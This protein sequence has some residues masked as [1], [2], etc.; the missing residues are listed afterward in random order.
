ANHAD[1]T[2]AAPPLND[3]AMH[4][5]QSTGYKFI[6]L[7]G[8]VDSNDNG[9]IDSG[10]AT[11]HYVIDTDAFLDEDEVHVHHDLA[12]G[13]QFIIQGWADMSVVLSGVDV[14]AHQTTMTA[15]DLPLAT[16]I[17]DSLV[18]SLGPD[19]DE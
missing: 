15:D 14:M 13:E 11:F 6:V 5:D 10:D 3:L 12:V 4:V 1:P 18:S 16:Q 17:R 19:Q 8:H 2:T 7:A 9:V